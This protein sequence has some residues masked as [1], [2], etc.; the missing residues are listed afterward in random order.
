MSRGPRGA[1]PGWQLDAPA[2][3]ERVC[4]NEERIG[5]LA[6]KS[7]ESRIDLALVLALRTWICSPMARAAGSTSLNVVSAF[8]AA[9]GLTSTATELAAGTNSRRASSRFAADSA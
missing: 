3:E 1:P 7:C 6:H 5:P 8:R 4:A 2:V 9:A